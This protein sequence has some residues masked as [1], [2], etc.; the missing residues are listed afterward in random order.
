M[1]LS[2]REL[3]VLLP[4]FAAAAQAETA[5]PTLR[6]TAYDFNALHGKTDPSGARKGWAVFNGVTTRGM[7]MSVHISELAPGQSPHPPHQHANEEII[8]LTQGTVEVEFNGRVGELGY[9]E[10][11]TIGPGSVVYVG[12]NDVHGMRNIGTVPAKYFVVELEGCDYKTE[13]S[14]S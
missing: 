14:K 3:A 13:S 5:Q 2:R 12:S 11:S 7:H 1:N 8:M 10:K 9:G 4:A 6:S